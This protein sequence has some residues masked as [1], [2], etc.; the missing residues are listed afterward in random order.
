MYTCM[1]VCVCVS[2]SV[3][4]CVHVPYL[5]CP[6]VCSPLW[7]QH[8]CTPSMALTTY[9][10]LFHRAKFNIAVLHEF[11]RLHKFNGLDLVQALRW[12]LT[13]MSISVLPITFSLSLHA[14]FAQ[15][16]SL[17]YLRFLVPLSELVSSSFFL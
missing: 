16:S 3:C 7:T 9:S 2:V 11:V 15:F 12:V 6:D 13:R 4:A 17:G 14:L 5:C 8:T 1:C 10:C